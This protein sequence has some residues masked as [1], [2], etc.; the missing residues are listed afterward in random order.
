MQDVNGLVPKKWRRLT[1]GDFQ[2]GEYWMRSADQDRTDGC[3][4]LVNCGWF[5]GSQTVEWKYG[6]AVTCRI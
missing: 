2:Y 3:R 6:S 1:Y 4:C 5:H